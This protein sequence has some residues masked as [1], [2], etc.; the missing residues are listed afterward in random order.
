MPVTGD[1]FTTLHGKKD[2]VTIVDDSDM[3]N[4]R[5]MSFNTLYVFI[6]NK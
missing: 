3:K 1:K 2:I 5:I 6:Y 4:V